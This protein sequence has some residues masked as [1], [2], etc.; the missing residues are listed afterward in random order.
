LAKVAHKALASSPAER[1]KSV[2]ELRDALADHLTGSGRRDES[3]SIVAEVAE[4]I[5][6]R[7]FETFGH[8]ELIGIKSKLDRALRLWPDNPE[9]LRWRDSADEIHARRAAQSGD[10]GLAHELASG[11]SPANPRRQALLDS[12]GAQ[13]KQA[14][15]HASQRRVTLAAC[16]LML[17][18]MSAG[19]V[20][21][22]FERQ[23]AL[24]KLDAQRE[25]AEDAYLKTAK[26]QRAG[27][28]LLRFV[29]QDLASDIRDAGGSPEL[30]ERTSNKAKEFYRRV[31]T[32]AALD[33]MGRAHDEPG[34]GPG[35]FGEDGFP[36]GPGF[37]PEP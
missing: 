23:V 30:A 28:R 6:R 1:Q 18:L 4:S 36:E 12:I 15:R 5:P 20:W 19:G 37:A 35:T 29:L 31:R 2:E 27:E 24:E 25:R 8:A 9:A 11:L 14:S 33:L 32:E 26:A 17:F 13:A 3:R 22:L 16:L 21:H 10:L 34:D 7:D